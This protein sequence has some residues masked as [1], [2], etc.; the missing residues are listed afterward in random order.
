VAH[1]CD[2]R[3]VEV[4]GNVT[5]NPR[6]LAQKVEDSAPRRI[7]KGEP[8]G[9]ATKVDLSLHIAGRLE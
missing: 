6:P 5:G 1:D 7:G 4:G 2:P 3:D 8:N 9:A